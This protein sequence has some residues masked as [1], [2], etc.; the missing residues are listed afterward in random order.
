M[1]TDSVN[2]PI[3]YHFADYLK[4]NFSCAVQKISINAG[5]S[6]PTRDGTKGYG[7][8]TYCN[9]STF[10]PAYCLENNSVDVQ[11][12]Q[13]MQFFAGKKKNPKFLAYFQAYTNTY[14]ESYKLIEYFESALQFDDIVGLIVGTRPD[15]IS[16]EIL[17]Y[18]QKKSKQVYVAVEFGVESTD[19][20]SLA[21]I[22]R[23]HTF[24]ETQEAFFRSANRGIHLGAHLII[25]LPGESKEIIISH[26]KNISALPVDTLKLHHLQIVKGTIMAHQFETSRQNFNLMQSEQYFD[27]IA[28]FIAHLRPNIAIERFISQA[29]QNLLIAPDWKGL[30]NH[31]T[32]RLIEQVM[33]EKKLFQGKYFQ[34]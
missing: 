25:G 21:R 5:N 23:G 29:P 7:G 1:E 13:G 34:G 20:K 2:Q 14:D 28:E 30:K 9:I 4:K 17:D 8:C 12:K 19:N 22:N 32:G 26:A 18:L 11:I 33:K 6:C 10:T 15:C 24:E 16:D 27:L 3:I 31:Q